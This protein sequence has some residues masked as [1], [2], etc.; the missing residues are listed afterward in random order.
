M[1]VTASAS[2]YS[3]CINVSIDWQFWVHEYINKLLKANIKIRQSKI[4]QRETQTL[5]LG[6]TLVM[7][8]GLAMCARSRE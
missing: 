6:Q 2:L 7:T 3:Q 8:V 1:E 5:K 4:A